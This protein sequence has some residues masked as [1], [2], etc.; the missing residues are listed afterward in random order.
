MT[1]P[2]YL[3]VTA[4]FFNV[5]VSSLSPSPEFD[6]I[7]IYIYITTSRPA[8]LIYMHKKYA[9]PINAF[10]WLFAVFSWFAWGKRRWAGLNS[11]VIE[12]V[13]LDDDDGRDDRKEA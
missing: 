3:P 7:Y 6:N 11:A 2:S 1:F 8:K 10:V 5:S 9:L 4:E 12:R 13:L